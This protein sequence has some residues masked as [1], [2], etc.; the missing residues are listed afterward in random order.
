MHARKSLL[1][2]EESAWVKSSG[3]PSFDVTMGSFDGAE[4]CELVGLYI[5]HL[6]GDQFGTEYMGL[7]RDD[8]LACSHGIDGPTSDRMRKNIIRLFKSLGLSITIQ[9]NLKVVNFLDVT[10]NLSTGTFQPYNKPNDRPLYI[11]TKSNHPPCIIKS[12]P[13]S[14]SR[15]INN[16]SSNKEMFDAAAPYYNQALSASGYGEIIEFKPSSPTRQPTARRRVR[17]VIWFNPPFSTNVKTNIASR[18]LKL[19][20]KHFPKTHKLAK[21]FNR[22]NVKVSYSCLPNIASSIQAHN[23]KIL[24][25]K[26]PVAAAKCNCRN[27]DACPLG[28]KCLERSIVYCGNVVSSDQDDGANYI[29]VTENTFKDRNYKHRNSFK[30]ENKINSTELSKH[31]W[32]LKRKGIANPVINWSIIDHAN[33]YVN[34]SK[35]CNLCLTEKYHIIMSPLNLLNKRSELVSKCRH[36]NKHYLS[37]YKA[38]P[39]DLS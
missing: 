37:N 24:S 34:G 8:G 39:P 38:V 33:S 23:K 16:I 22:N 14:I 25:D 28:G 35:K 32:E 1:F 11:N 18:F 29:G 21:V 7:Y 13:E 15:R 31:V 30:Y 17:N 4:L 26:Q 19:I 12:I 3:D 10:F 36:E 6:L 20:D 27:K 9:T 2:A 5:L